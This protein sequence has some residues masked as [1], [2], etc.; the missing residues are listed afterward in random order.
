MPFERFDTNIAGALKQV[1]LDIFNEESG[2]RS[3]IPNVVIVIADGQ[4]NIN[5]LETR[6]A[7]RQ[8]KQSTTVYVVAVITKYFHKEE[9]EYIATDPDSDHYFESPTITTLPILKCRL[10]KQ[11]CKKEVFSQCI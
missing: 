9:L 5:T 11:V 1:K 10:L 6:P 7:A 3:Y 4:S 8:L 2:D